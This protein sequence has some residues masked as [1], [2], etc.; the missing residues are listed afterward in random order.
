MAADVLSK[1]KSKLSEPLSFWLLL[2][3]CCQGSLV[4]VLNA[5]QLLKS[6]FDEGVAPD[7][8][9]PTVACT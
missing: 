7:K 2:P 3:S 9:K 8:W 4:W 6:L 5:V 1:A